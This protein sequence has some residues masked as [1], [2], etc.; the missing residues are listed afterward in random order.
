MDK[1]KPYCCIKHLKTLHPLKNLLLGGRS[2]G[3]VLLEGGVVKKTYDKKSRSQIS[4]FEKEVAVLK[5]LQGCEYIPKLYKIDPKNKIIWLEYVGKNV[6]L[7]EDM[8]STVNKALKFIG[9]KYQ[10]YRVKNGKAKYSYK[11][12]F[13]ANICVNNEGKVY[14]IDFGS[15]L[16][17]IGTNKSF[18]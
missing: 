17:Q 9:E 4:R 6:T 12:L 11:D 8:K 7:T 2:K 10:V 15:N 16:W 18:F 13:P 3:V 14:L 1:K 5:R